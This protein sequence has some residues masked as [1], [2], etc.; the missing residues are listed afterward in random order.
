VIVIAVVN[1]KGGSAKTTTAAFTA[2]ALHEAGLTVAGVD[3]DGENESFAGWHEEVRFPFPVFPLV[4]PDLAHR[5][6]G[7]LGDRF[8][9]AVLDTPPMQEHRRVVRGAIEVA[10]HIVVPMAPTPMEYRRLPAVRELIDEVVQSRPA[11]DRPVV[12]VLLT[13]TVSGAASTGVWRRQIVADGWHVLAPT[14]GRLER[15]S[16]AYGDR[17][18]NA[19]N[20]AYG[21]AA[22]ELLDLEAA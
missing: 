10:T 17:I 15:Y 7:V 2:H 6:H 13:R 20:T 8:E 12:A 5:L 19:A 22:T 3:A 11:A 14:V 21:F 9:A 16:Q 1:L 4:V 18:I